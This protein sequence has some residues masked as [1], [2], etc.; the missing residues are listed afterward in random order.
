MAK[1][2][3]AVRVYGDLASAVWC[4]AS[5]TTGPVGLAAPAATFKDV[6]WLGDDGVKVARK[7]DVEKFKALQGGTTVK[8]KI[9]GTENTFSFQ[10]LEETAVVLGLMHAGSSGVTTTGVTTITVPGGMGSDPRAWVLDQWE[11][12]IQTRYIFPIGTI[13]DR[14]DIVMKNDE[15]T[16]Y[17]FTVEVTGD[18]SIITNSAAVVFPIP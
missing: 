3:A 10:C 13:G 16:V 11:G 14:G 9:T 4:A 7:V 6:G 1:N 8:T 12:I 2:L 18:F 15:M 17:E 5:G